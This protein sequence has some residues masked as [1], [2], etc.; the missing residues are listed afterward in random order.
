MAVKH[1]RRRKNESEEEFRVRE[2]EVAR[3]SVEEPEEHGHSFR[4]PFLHP[5]D[6]EPK[7]E[8]PAARVPA[9]APPPEEVQGIVAIGNLGVAMLSP[10]DALTEFEQVEFAEALH[11]YAEQSRRAR[12]VLY[13]LIGKSALVMFGSTCL[14]LLAPRLIRHGI[15]PPSV[16][17]MLLHVP[18]VDA[19]QVAEACGVEIQQ[20]QPDTAGEQW[21]AHAPTPPMPEREEAVA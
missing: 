19:S 16:G 1:I 9:K 14:A 21:A 20:A 8:K 7:S 5:S 10:R 18:G 17:P 12:Q 13:G 4:I 2:A 3:E 11:R 15:L 6:P